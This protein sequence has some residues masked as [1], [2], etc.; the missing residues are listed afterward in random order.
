MNTGF[1]HENAILQGHIKPRTRSPLV[2]PSQ[3]HKPKKKKMY[4]SKG[5]IRPNKYSP[6]VQQIVG[7]K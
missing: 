2:R 7:N 1:R 6:I 5:K 3:N 4:K